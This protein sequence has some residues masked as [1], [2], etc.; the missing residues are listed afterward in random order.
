MRAFLLTAAIL[1]AS[2]GPARAQT[3]ITPEIVPQGKL[4]VAL[5]G[6]N[7]ILVRRRPDGGVG[8][9]S[10]DLGR[11]IA[12]R[13]GVPFEAMVYPD[14]D[15]Y[16][17]SFGKG[18]WDVAI[19]PRTPAAEATSD[20]SPDFMLVDNIYVA[21][22]GRDF[23][24]AGQVDRPGVKIAVV[25]NGAPDQF[26]SR[27]LKSAELVR[28]RGD[29]NEMIEALRSGK[30]DLYGSNA[31]N[32]HAVAEG[33]PGAKIVPGAFRSVRMAVAFPK[34]RSAAAQE[35]LAEI[36]NEAKRTG[37]FQKAID[38]GGFK[39]VRTAPN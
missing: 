19:G 16:A 11:L 18:Q 23:A 12:E 37:L 5:V 8:G 29:R 13:L 7:P 15:A 9:V 21:A 27:A 22:P 30:A 31:E 2:Y 10:V 32:V 39:A 3:A 24:D 26:L 17:Q 1:I 36:V 25:L 28:I 33:L 34:G 6:S 35:K 4:R 20:F 14:T 38:N